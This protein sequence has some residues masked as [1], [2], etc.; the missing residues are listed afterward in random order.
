LIPFV[1]S[2][3]NHE[4]NQLNQRLLK[5]VLKL[6]APETFA[7]DWK[8]D[9][10]EEAKP[11]YEKLGPRAWWLYQLTR[12]LPLSWWTVRTGLSADQL[13]SWAKQGEWQEALWRGWLE[14]QTQTA[15]PAWAKAFLSHLPS[16]P[17]PVDLFSLVLTLPPEDREGYW[18]KIL[19]GNPPPAGLGGLLRAFLTALPD[20]AAP[21]S[22]EF[23]RQVFERVADYLRHAQTLQDYYLRETLTEFACLIPP[24]VFEDA[25]A[26][27]AAIPDAVP[28]YGVAGGR[29][30]DNLELRKHLHSHPLLTRA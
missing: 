13:L 18:L 21:F 7:P 12:A 5:Q 24:E 17:F 26:L 8:A 2:L 11:A 28:S 27:W 14:M 16:Q 23:S 3:S 6:D 15:D 10:L 4:R 22:A 20:Y 29:F 1:V 19:Q 30:A 25:E 9:G